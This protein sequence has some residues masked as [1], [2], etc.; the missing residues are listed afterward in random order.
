M[1]REE[2]QPWYMYEI[3]RLTEENRDLRQSLA[4]LRGEPAASLPS[5]PSSLDRNKRALV[6]ADGTVV[7]QRR[8]AA[9]PGTCARRTEQMC[10]ALAKTRADSLACQL[11]ANLA[12]RGASLDGP[13]DNETD[14]FVG[15]GA[16]LHGRHC[17]EWHAASCLSEEEED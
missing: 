15:I 11:G 6:N 3:R 7:C 8:R 2:E 12:S 1:A 10:Q 17:T 4:M 5:L 9:D 16:R 13:D 14:A